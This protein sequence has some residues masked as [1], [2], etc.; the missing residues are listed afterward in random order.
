MLRL[1]ATG[2]TSAEFLPP[3][4]IVPDVGEISRLIIFIVVVLPQPDG[5][6][7]TVMLPS[8][9]SRLRFGI[10]V[11]EPYDLR[12]RSKTTAFAIRIPSFRCIF[13]NKK[14][15]PMQGLYL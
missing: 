3:T 4:V 9:I 2:S 12:T 5:P 14:T 6:T 15:P 13:E 7:S 10:T 8:G 11:V 1:S